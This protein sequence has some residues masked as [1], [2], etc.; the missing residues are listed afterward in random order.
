M[1]KKSP[2]TGSKLLSAL[3][4]DQ[5]E[6][7]LDTVGSDI[8]L[9]KVVHE[10]KNTDPDMAD[11][12]KQILQPD[13]RSKSQKHKADRVISDSRLVEEWKEL[14]G[15]WYDI[16]AEIGDEDGKYAVQEHHWEE[17]Y[18]DGS[19]VASDLEKVGA[20]MYKRVDAVYDLINEPDLFIKAIDEIDEAIQSYPEWMGADYGDGCVLEYQTTLCILKWLL[21]SCGNEKKQGVVILDKIEEVENRSDLVSLDMAAIVDIIT[22]LP[23]PLCREIH[24]ELQTG[25]FHEE[26][27]NAYS[28]WNAIAHEFERR[29]N[30]ALYFERCSRDL[31][32]NWQ[33][34]EPLI[35]KAMKEKDWKSAESWLV[36]TFAS[37]RHRPAAPYWYPEQSLLIADDRI[38]HNESYK[39]SVANLF[40]LW[41]TV[42]NNLDNSERSIASRFQAMVIRNPEKLVKIVNT[43]R[44]LRKESNH[45]SLAMLFKQWQ[46]EIVHRSLPFS[47]HQ[48]GFH[49][50]WIH[51]AITSLTEPSGKKDFEGKLDSWLHLLMQNSGTFKKQWKLLAC[52]TYDLAGSSGL[53][54]RFP[55]LFKTAIERFGRKSSLDKSRI[56]L[57]VPLCPPNTADTVME[58]WKKQFVY[59]IPDPAGSGSDYL[60]PV[61][62]VKVLLEINPNKYSRI[63]KQWHIKHHRRRSLWQAMRN[64]KLPVNLG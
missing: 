18:F 64:A 31:E 43:F 4:Q 48:D 33:N 52:L 40:K 5:I 56:S 28:H 54:K 44:E 58:I 45:E 47:I 35:G 59:I 37:Y 8:L 17:P 32:K 24:E 41:S 34:G 6:K 22:E 29:Y 57:F 27:E 46:D 1:A 13:I 11:T 61:A 55:G 51:W 14:W 15:Q 49:D 63:V 26:Q 10:G 53:R 30:K 16:I 36:K 25:R 21:L 39:S 62:W 20:G 19:A 23:E 60:R 7:L 50:T 12:V 3:T 2:G 42:C 38:Y 9:E